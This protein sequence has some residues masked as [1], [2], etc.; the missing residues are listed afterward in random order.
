MDD[1]QKKINNAFFIVS[2]AVEGF[3]KQIALALRERGKRATPGFVYA[4]GTRRDVRY[5]NFYENF[6]RWLVAIFE[7]NY[8]GFEYLWTD[9][10]VFVSDLQRRK[11][12]NLSATDVL[13]NPPFPDKKEIMRTFCEIE[14]RLEMLKGCFEF[15]GAK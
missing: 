7:A 5:A 2:G 15:E 13:I 11:L 4:Q 8:I 9:L 10:N 14:Y 12:K 3:T 1:I 6:L